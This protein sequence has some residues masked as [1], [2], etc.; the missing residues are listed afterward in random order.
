MRV[1]LA[2]LIS[3]VSCLG[4]GIFN[5]EDKGPRGL[6]NESH[7]VKMTPDSVTQRAGDTLTLQ[8]YL[9]PANPNS[10]NDDYPV[11]W[12]IVRGGGSVSSASTL[13]DDNGHATI[14]WT[15]G[16]SIVQQ[17]R[18]VTDIP[19]PDTMV[20]YTSF[21][22]RLAMISGD[23]QMIRLGNGFT[24]LTVE[25]TEG[26][27]SPVA[28]ETIS[29][30]SFS[31]GISAAGTVVTDAVGRAS[32]IPSIAEP[33]ELRATTVRAQVAA[34]PGDNVD[35][36]VL[37]P[38][39]LVSLS[40]NNQTGSP[41]AR[42]PEPVVLRWMDMVTGAS[43]PPTRFAWRVSS[44]G[45]ILDH[46]TTD[47]TPDSSGMTNG[48]VLGPLTGR[49][50][51]YISRVGDDIDGQ[52]FIDATAVAGGAAGCGGIGLLHDAA[53]GPVLASERWT[54][55]GSP[56]VVRGQLHFGAGADL[57]IDPGVTV[58]LESN[59]G[60]FLEGT[61]RAIGTPATPIR[62]A[63]ADSTQPWSNITLSSL[64][65]DLNQISNARIEYAYTAIVA[66]APVRID[67]TIIRQSRNFAILI[68][69]S[70]STNRVIHTTVDTTGSIS[71]G[72]VI[73]NAPGTIFSST[74]RG[75]AG[76]YA[77][78][79]TKV[80]VTLQECVISG[81]SGVGVYVGSVTGTQ[82]GSCNLTSNT[83]L[84]VN[85]GGVAVDARS[86]W[87]GTAAGPTVGGPNGVSATV[88]ASS[89]RAGVIDVGYRP[90]W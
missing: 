65:P 50:S 88:D 48:W 79:I 24:A 21:V 70:A 39:R 80:D 28:G 83:G 68:D 76:P 7:L 63:A 23:S 26:D 18:A 40:G 73:I 69:N 36:R 53:V 59:A 49:Q 17:V 81:N 46:D 2:I 11:R 20:L 35:F 14:V 9:D 5:D 51:L 78:L 77:V 27:G 86:N 42:L 1:A 54:A 19:G 55:A 31:P 6:V 64:F 32:L 30:Q 82:I 62:F 60:L 38:F 37:S 52:K 56:H 3:T 43:G 12:E 58:C 66:G 25:L 57:T 15:L 61:L 29:W 90:A 71:N 33:G 45:G 41:G 72:A 22:R 84:A 67:S 85:G 13:T 89:P 87:W 16:D 44:G 75:A 10:P 47:W 8:V 34:R 74:V 4:C